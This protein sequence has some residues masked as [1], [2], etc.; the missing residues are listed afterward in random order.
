MTWEDESIDGEHIDRFIDDQ[1]AFKS[2]GTAR[3]RFYALRSFSEWFNDVHLN[4]DDKEITDLRAIDV[5]DYLK[6]LNKEGYAPKTIA[7]RYDA[8][9]QLFKE[10][11]GEYRVIDENP[12]EN[13]NYRKVSSLMDG[14]KKTDESSD[15]F[16]H[17]TPEEVD[18]MCE[19][20]PKPKTRNKLL[21]RLLFQTGM[22][23]HECRELKLK[24]VDTERRSIEVYSSKPQK[25]KDRW[26]TAYYQPSLDTLMNIWINHSRPRYTTA[27]NSE[28]LF[29]TNRSEKFGKTR[30]EDL[31]RQTAELAE[32][33]SVLNKDVNGIEHYR[34]TPHAF[35]H[36]HCMQ[37]VK[38]G[39]DISFVAE[40]VG[41]Q[42]L[43]MTR[44]YLD[45]I[46]T[47]IPNA[48]RKFGR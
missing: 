25:K 48:Y 45:A 31:V 18:L 13:I 10:L 12:V 14:T 4:G 40:M 38:Q 7:A 17:I 46:D 15:E 30:I 32:I 43:D 28:Y 29:V 8:V 26:R 23:S 11:S 33:Q 39:I 47:E 41:H 42:S 36:G 2:E 24:N 5:T 1:K 6:W 27:K 35:R 9:D 19:H 22:R 37:A 20:A 3:A 21:F 34:I 16:V 44:K